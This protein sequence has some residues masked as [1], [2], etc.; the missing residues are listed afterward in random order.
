M[1]ILLIATGGM[2]NPGDQFIRLGVERLI[3]DSRTANVKLVRISKENEKEI[4]TPQPFD[5]VIVCGMPLWWNNSV[6]TSQSIGWWGELIRGWVSDRKNDFLVL[7]A[8]PVVGLGGLHDPEE[9]QAAMDE[10]VA[11]AWKVTSR[12][13]TGHPGIQESICPAAF[14][15]APETLAPHRRLCNLMPHGAHDAHFNPGEAAVWRERLPSL[16]Q[17]LRSRGFEFVAH[18]AEEWR[19]ARRWWSDNEIHFPA[20]AEHYLKLY[21]ESR[22]FIGNRLHGAMRAAM[23]G[24]PAVAIGYDSRV[25]MLKPFT[26]NVFTPS[27]LP[28]HFHA[29]VWPSTLQPDTIKRELKINRAIMKEFLSSC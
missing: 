1:K 25:D 14:A 8:G 22:F 29:T 12:Q 18:D 27:G 3:R 23:N 15:V 11:R 28:E 17:E 19:L 9:F 13:P 4:M 20:T 16:A 26:Q 6:S 24:T 2:D 10:T 7:G 21:S 5:K